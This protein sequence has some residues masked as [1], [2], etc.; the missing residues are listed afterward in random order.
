MREAVIAE[1]KAKTQARMQNLPE[2]EHRPPAEPSAE[3]EDPP[4]VVEPE[5]ADQYFDE[6]S[7]VSP[8]KQDAPPDTPAQPDPPPEPASSPSNRNKPPNEPALII[9]LTLKILDRLK[10]NVEHARWSPAQLVIELIHSA[11][12]QGYPTIQFGDQ[13]VARSGT[14]RAFA[15]NPLENILKI[16]SGQGVFQFV[17]TPENPDYQHWLSYF[18]RQKCEDPEKSAQQVCLFSLQSYL[19]SVDDFT[20]D[21]WSKNILVEN[22]SVL[23]DS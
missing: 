12:H 3:I 7:E 5:E 2:P 18:T 11:L 13:L 19:E 4:L 17:V 22:Y 10:R 23:P 20:P 1:E 9:P 16:S 15:R 21:G 6:A 14:Y 8:A